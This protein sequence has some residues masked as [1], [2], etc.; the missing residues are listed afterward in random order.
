MNFKPDSMQYL[1]QYPDNILLARKAELMKIRP[2][3][4]SDTHE[5]TALW[6]A[7]VE[8]THDFLNADDIAHYHDQVRD[9]YLPALEVWVA[10]DNTGAALGF[11]G[12][13][14]NK[15]E[16]LFVDPM[17]HKQGTGRALLDHAHK[18]KGLLSVDV[19]EQNPQAL[20]F[21][22]KYGFTRTGR[23]ETDSEGKPFPLIHLAQPAC[24]P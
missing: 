13:A 14:E 24:F 20:G 6:Q 2:F 23:S 9:I 8:A 4:T 10:T 15:V 1:G 7:A 17:M 21:Y 19:N 3:I 16:M 22:L 5:L 18:L 11:I 12:L